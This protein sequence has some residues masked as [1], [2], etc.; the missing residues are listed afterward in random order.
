MVKGCLISLLAVV[1][2]AACT[3]DEQVA[4]ESDGFVIQ[5]HDAHVFDAT[6]TSAG[7]SLR[8]TVNEVQKDI[9]D[10]TFDFGD[11]VIGFHLDYSRGLGEFQPNGSPLDAA[12][13]RLV[14]QLYEQLTKMPEM[15]ANGQTRV[16]EVTFR[17]ANYMQIVP[18]GESLVNHNIVAQQ[19]WSHI[20]CT[21]NWQWIGASR[22][23][24]RH[25]TGID[26]NGSCSGGS[27][28]G[29]KGR[30]GTSCGPCVGTTAYT[31]DCAR[32]DWGIGSFS[33]A[34]DDFTFASNNCSC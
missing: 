22:I 31:Y 13:S 20:S 19:G 1:G 11:P 18:T 16:D 5:Q 6:V 26:P 8:V 17:M 15:L 2:I 4:P 9:V 27:G 14:A 10:V 24:G 12:Q 34:S 30:C 25:N 29:C 28:N 33:A 7:T 23:C 3:Q 21:C 32:H